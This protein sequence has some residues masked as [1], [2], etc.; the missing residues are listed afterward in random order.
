MFR[1]KNAMANVITAKQLE[2]RYKGKSYC[3]CTKYDSEEAV[4]FF[5]AVP[6]IY[7]K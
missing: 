2:I 4:E 6:Y 1:V 7:R 3:R 5:Q